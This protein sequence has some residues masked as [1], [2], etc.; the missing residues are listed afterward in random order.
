MK[1]FRRKITPNWVR[2]H[3]QK[4][5]KSLYEG[6]LIGEIP[7]CNGNKL[8][9][10]IRENCICLIMGYSMSSYWIC[11]IEYIYQLNQMLRIYKIK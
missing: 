2:K 7:E 8:A 1:L 6:H 4:P 10:D 9:I 3:Y 11:D 5:F